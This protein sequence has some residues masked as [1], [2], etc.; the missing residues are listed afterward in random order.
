MESV[1]T[2]QR[3]NL[4]QDWYWK[5]LGSLETREVKNWLSEFPSYGPADA[6]VSTS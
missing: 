5:L 6:F 1:K 4:K 2:G 3:Q